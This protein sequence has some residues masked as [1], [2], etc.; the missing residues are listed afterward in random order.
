M[1]HDAGLLIGVSFS[2]SA[3]LAKDG[4]S[5]IHNIVYM[6]SK[7]INLQATPTARLSKC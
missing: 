4:E 3:D 1:K 5:E 7:L 2:V 6:Y